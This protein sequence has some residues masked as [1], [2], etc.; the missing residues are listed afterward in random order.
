MTNKEAAKRF[1]DER[2]RCRI[3][4]FVYG[5]G[6]LAALALMIMQETRSALLIFVLLMIVYFAVVRSAIKQYTAGWREFC[7]RLFM[8]KHFESVTYKY[9]VVAEKLPL[10]T[11]HLMMPAGEK[12]KVVAHNVSTGNK[13]GIDALV[14]DATIPS[15]NGSMT[16]FNNGCW[17]GMTFDSKAAADVYAVKGELLSGNN[18]EQWLTGEQGLKLC[19]PPEDMPA[20][21]QFYSMN[22][23]AELPDEAVNPLKALL[24]SMPGD[25]VIRVCGEGLFVFL[26]HRLINKLP[27]ALK[28]TLTE[29]MI[30]QLSF[31][32]LDSAYMLALALRKKYIGRAAGDE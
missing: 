23:E 19:Q 16:R 2:R 4:Y 26:P 10:L 30:D 8:E 3:L 12:G 31:P 5:L 21:V 28:F 22:G 11:S 9:R 17:M 6:M 1:D 25:G 24:K 29:A 15:G 27:P 20:G 13:A 18:Y 7:V 14:M 32:E